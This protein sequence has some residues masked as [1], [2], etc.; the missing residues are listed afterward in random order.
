MNCSDSTT[1]NRTATTMLCANERRPSAVG[2]PSVRHVNK[3]AAMMTTT[4]MM[5][6]RRNRLRV[7]ARATC[8]TTTTLS[9]MVCRLR[10]RTWR[11]RCVLGLT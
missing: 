1:T 2:V 8:Q 5:R 10:V 9:R 7:T 4:L 11:T 6:R 3:V